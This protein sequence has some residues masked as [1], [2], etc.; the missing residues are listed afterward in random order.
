MVIVIKLEL[1]TFTK[2]Y[3]LSN[4]QKDLGI[5]MVTLSRNATFLKFQ[6][7]IEGVVLGERYHS[8]LVG[9]LKSLLLITFTCF[10]FHRQD[11]FHIL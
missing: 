3:V 11:Y 9:P 2:E 10:S 7:S 4:E 5:T 1:Q 8:S 6:D